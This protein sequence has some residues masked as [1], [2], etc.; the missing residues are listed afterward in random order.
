VIFL[1]TPLCLPLWSSLVSPSP[2]IVE[3]LVYLQFLLLENDFPPFP[4]DVRVFSAFSYRHVSSS[5][6][7]ADVLPRFVCAIA[8]SV[9]C[10]LFSGDVVSLLTRRPSSSG[11]RNSLTRKFR[12]FLNR[13]FPPGLYSFTCVRFCFLFRQ[14]G[15]DLL[16]Q[17]RTSR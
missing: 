16:L 3:R 17:A 14:P 13:R 2:A 7:F 12:L 10:L 1:S 11:F 8:T 5:P 6:F 4:P 15:K 9:M